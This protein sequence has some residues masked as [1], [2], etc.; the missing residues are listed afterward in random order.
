MIILAALAAFA[1]AQD[2]VPPPADWGAALSEDAR[3]FHDAVAENHAGPVDAENPGFGDLL[4]N[5]LALA[6]ERA[7]TADSYPHWYYALREYEASFDDGHL[8]LTDWQGM[9]QRWVLQWP[10]FMTGLRDYGGRER[11]EVV[12]VRDE[13]GPPAGAVLV[14]CDGRPAEALAAGILGRT[15]GRWNLKSQRTRHAANLFVDQMNPYVRRPETCEFLVDGA[16][17]TYDLAW[18]ALPEALRDEGRAVARSPRHF[19]P[20]EMRGFSGGVW[21][22]LGSFESDPASEPGRRL[23]ALLAEVEDSA[24]AVRA[25]PMVVFDLRGNNGGSSLWSS[26]ITRILWGEERVD[27]LGP[28]SQGVDWRVSPGNLETIEYYRDEVFADQPDALVWATEIAEGMRA[29]M[30]AGEPLWRQGDGEARPAAPEGPGPMTGR[31]YVLTDSGCAS[32]CLDAVDFFTAMG[33]VTVGQETSAD[34][35]YMDIRDISLPGGR[36]AAYVP[37]KVYR[38]R[39]R[40]NNES[41]AP[42]HEWS[43]PMSDTAGIE[44]WLIGLDAA[45]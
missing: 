17:R 34:S 8:G 33:A 45:R 21:I 27:A 15:A 7:G 37:M 9:G 31:V 43:G 13:A 32:A 41:V 25:A 6:L 19:A 28:R 38:G 1:T 18:R 35:V 29:A 36:V 23:T 5:G 10:G 42:V 3:A 20:V 26:R 12:F 22:S 24:A 4:A 14:Q 39:G 44:A 40:G 11:H 30:Q 2:P 16:S